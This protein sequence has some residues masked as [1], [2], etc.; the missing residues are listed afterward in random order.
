MEPNVKFREGLLCHRTCA[1]VINPVSQKVDEE[2]TFRL[3]ARGVADVGGIVGD[4]FDNHGNTTTKPGVDVTM[5][6]TTLARVLDLVNAPKR[7][8]Y[9]S[10]DIEGAEYHALKGFDFRRYTI[11]LIT[12]E[13]PK[14]KTHQSD[15]GQKWI[16]VCLYVQWRIR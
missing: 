8:D 2:V 15:T 4:E 12:V 3:E 14:E 10:L 13:R 1:V 6:T 5:Y 9:M 11:D 7:I 16:L